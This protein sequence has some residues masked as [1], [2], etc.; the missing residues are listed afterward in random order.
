MLPILPFV[1]LAIWQDGAEL[2]WRQLLHMDVGAWLAVAYLASLLA[3]MLWTQ[4]LKRDPAWRVT[5]FFLLVL[6]L[7]INQT[8]AL[9]TLARSWWVRA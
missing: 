2:V 7:L 8:D 3:Y 9:R 4:L 6:G 1:W 5:P